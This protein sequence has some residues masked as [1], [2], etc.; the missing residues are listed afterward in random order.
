MQGCKTFFLLFVYQCISSPCF[1]HC[2]ECVIPER[3]NKQRRSK[4][5]IQ[6][7]KSSMHIR[8]KRHHCIEETL[9]FL[10]SKH[11]TKNKV[12]CTDRQKMKFH[13]WMQKYESCMQAWFGCW[14]MT[15]GRVKQCGH[16][17]LP[18]FILTSIL[19]MSTLY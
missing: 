17:G 19:D 13:L 10:F 14:L 5:S 4:R 12:T 16:D 1:N 3:N 7:K 15:N 2:K 8:T 9:Q 18:C 6:K 11:I